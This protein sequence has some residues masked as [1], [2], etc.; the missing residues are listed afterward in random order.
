MIFKA[1]LD[2]VAKAV[3]IG[4]TILF[5]TMI[6]VQFFLIHDKD[7]TIQIFTSILL[8]VI[9][10]I[11]YILRPIQ[12]EVTDN[13]IIVRRPYKD[14]MIPRS[15]II[16][17]QLLDKEDLAWT[18]RTF[19]SGAFF[20]YYGKFANRKQGSMTW[21]ATKNKTGAVLIITNQHKKIVF[22]PDEPEAFVTALNK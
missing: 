14:V 13:D 11:A 21:Y 22:T 3:T 6:I 15:E 7:K 1:S 12:Y 4:V 17:V 8:I 20:G 18:V 16:S 10:G 9:Y 2:K 19:G 5:A